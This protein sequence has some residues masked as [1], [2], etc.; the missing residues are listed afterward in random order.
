M[1]P[2]N[3]FSLMGKKKDPPPLD[4][5]RLTPEARAKPTPAVTIR[6]IPRKAAA[7]LDTKPV[8]P[9]FRPGGMKKLDNTPTVATPITNP[10]NADPMKPVSPGS[11]DQPQRG[12]CFFSNNRTHLSPV[13]PGIPAPISHLNS[14]NSHSLRNGGAVGPP[15]PSKD[16][17][18][19]RGLSGEGDT[20]HKVESEPILKERKLKDAAV[21]VST[22]EDILGLYASHL[23]INAQ[24]E[25]MLSADY[26]ERRFYEIPV[27]LDS[28]SVSLVLA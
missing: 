10:T 24:E 18:H 14:V 20:L 8:H 7:T 26:H 21:V 11:P 19:V 15:W 23:D 3:A 17:C 28:Q 2:V 4:P 27:M 25:D 12:S 9:F 5:S 1:S 6:D 13:R 22:E 16:N